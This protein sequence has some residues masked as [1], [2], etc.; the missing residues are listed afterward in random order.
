ME[1]IQEER[2]ELLE[3]LEEKLRGLVENVQSC[4]DKG[5]QSD[6]Y[7]RQLEAFKRDQYYADLKKHKI[8]VEGVK[9]VSE[10][11]DALKHR[12]E[13]YQKKEAARRAREEAEQ[14][15]KTKKLLS[16]LALAAVICIAIMVIVI[17]IATNQAPAEMVEVKAQPVMD[18]MGGT[19]QK[20]VLPVITQLHL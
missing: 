18:K 7:K 13:T 8:Y 10:A 4:S 14:K 9:R 11:I 2:R 12:E 17:V 5:T 20:Y 1:L 3:S 16:I 19:L 6:F 15:A